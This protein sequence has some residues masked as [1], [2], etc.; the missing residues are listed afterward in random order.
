MMKGNRKFILLFF[1]LFTVY[2]VA[3]LNR[4]KP[5]DWTVTMAKTDKNP[6]GGYILFNRLKDLFS[7]SQVKAATN[8]IYNILNN[9]KVQSSAY[10]IISPDFSP[11]KNDL[12]ELRQYVHSGNTA[13]I[14]AANFNKEALQTLR[15]KTSTRFTILPNDSIS[16]NLVNTSL[17]APRDYSFLKNTINEYFTKI[18]TAFAT[19]LG[20][21]DKGQP[22]FIRLSYGKGSIFLHAAPICFSNYFL[23]FRNNHQYASSALSYISADAKTIYWDEYYKPGGQRRQTPLYFILNNNYLLWAFRLAMLGM[24][25]Y[26]L[27][28]IKR[29]QRIIPVIEPLRNSS[30][31]FVQT[32]SNV[33]FNQKDNAGIADKKISYFFEFIRNRFYMQTTELDEQFVETL[34]RKSG[35]ET[36]EIREIVRLLNTV[37]NSHTVDDQLLLLLDKNTDHFYKQV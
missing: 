33:Y 29:R 18:D 11:S 19:I 13:F 7:A 35:V 20:V 17:K 15:L 26:V 9:H 1:V 31:D 36:G 23:L 28:A 34:S 21:N 14:S 6:Y 8:P 27:F 37:Q 32:V 3:E 30:L 12:D 2:V 16:I 10:I 25:I 4:P 5:L 24:L 22:N